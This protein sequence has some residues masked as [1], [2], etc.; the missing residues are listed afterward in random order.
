MSAKILVVDDSSL[1]R[2][3]VRQLLEAMGH[4]VVEASDGM[5]ALEVFHV[6]KPE[7]V[8]L[9]MVMSGMYGLDVLAKMREMNP[10]VRVLVSTSDVQKSTADQ[11]KAA[12]AKGLL[13]KPVSKE[14]LTPAVTLLLGGGDLWN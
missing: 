12:G 7:L 9:D 13:N 1:A 4:T 14:K 3:T 2:R 6:E 8:V 10:E 11:V 5:Q